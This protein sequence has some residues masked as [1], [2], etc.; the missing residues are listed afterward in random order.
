[1]NTHIYNK[2]KKTAGISLLSCFFAF[3]PST[4]MAQQFKITAKIP[5]IK[6]GCEVKV[7][8]NNG[9]SRDEIVK[10][11]TDDGGFTLTGTVTNPM[12]ASIEIND[13][14][15]YAK[16]EY[17]QDRGVKFMLENT[18][19]TISAAHFDSIPR[20]YEMGGTPLKL[21]RNVCVTGGDIQKHYQEWRDYIYEAELTEW[22]AS[23]QLWLYQ[24]ASDT[25][26][27]KRDARLMSLMKNTARAAQLVVD[28]RNARF[29]A[30]H[31]TYAVSVMLQKRSM[32]DMFVYTNEELDSIADML[33]DNEDHAGYEQ[34]KEQIATLR[35]YTKGMAYTDISVKAADGTAKRL[36]DCIVKGKYNYIDMWA[37][38]CGPCR[39]AIPAVKEL[40]AKLGD[41]LNVISLSVD[42]D[43]AAWQR[44]MND[45]K[46]PWT[47]LIAPKEST[48]I[49]QEAYNLTSI[50]YLLVIN[51]EGKI[52]MSTHEPETADDFII[53]ELSK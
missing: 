24:F 10:G 44:A 26:R 28:H 13:K 50:P 32:E 43:E 8:G 46:M 16:G 41:K 31:P 15:Q 27:G 47:Q 21:E 38:W 3:S 23:H 53:S 48:K 4:V 39:A 1:M 35:K 49:L 19:I 18:G 25:P 36:S 22:Q 52:I 7:I 34:L 14:P 29:I 33:K 20:I 12:L 5:G 40:H 30:S 37:S 11:T 42:R 6:K 45:E 9:Y 2:V 17:P 51:P